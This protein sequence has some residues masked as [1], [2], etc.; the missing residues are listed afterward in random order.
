MAAYSCV[1]VFEEGVDTAPFTQTV[2]GVND[3]RTGTPFEAH[4]IL[5][6]GCLS[7]VND[8][9]PNSWPANIG[10][11][12]YHIGIA[13]NTTH[14]GAIS[15]SSLL[16]FG[17][18]KFCGGGTATRNSLL[19]ALAGGFGSTL[20][21]VGYLSAVAA[22]SV[23]I[24]WT[25]KTTYGFSTTRMALF[26]GGSD[27]NIDIDTNYNGVHA[28]TDAP[29]GVLAI[30]GLNTYGTAFSAAAGG[31]I[32]DTGMGW[33]I[34]DGVVGSANMVVINQQG[35][36]RSQLSDRLPISMAEGPP[37]VTSGTPIV[38]S[39]DPTSYTITG[40]GGEAGT[41]IGLLAFSGAGIICSS[42]VF[43]APATDSDYEL[44]LQLDPYFVL[45]ASVGNVVSSS[46]DTAQ[47]TISYGWTDR[48]NVCGAWTGENIVGNVSPQHGAAF[49]SDQYLIQTATPDGLNSILSNKMAL[50]PILGTDGLADLTFTDTDGTTPSIIWFA[51][52]VPVP[53]P[54]P[55]PTPVFRTREVVRR[56]LRR[57]PIVWSEKGGLQTRVR[58]NLFA[59]DMQPGVGT[60]GTPDPLVMIRASKDGGFTWGNERRLTAGRVGEFFDRIN[61]WQWG[62]GRDWVF[63]VA[64]TDPVT[65]NLVGAYL[66]AEGGEN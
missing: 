47:G 41:P 14:G 50:A 40:E 63:E 2:T 49:M 11:Y 10:G 3:G 1:Q 59:V 37:R 53:T 19:T 7:P 29:Q 18:G 62:Q 30:T 39:W 64:C 28:T 42:G 31:A 20:Q 32:S 36:L 17:I 60:S 21:D 55:P 4:T 23:D 45:F 25:T 54:P 24:T 57:A 33:A 38:S 6:F 5:F 9:Y 26:L 61:A 22:G 12:Q 43:S 56:R 65:W 58:I 16:A 13:R 15:G 51:V 44:D 46:V 66:D 48:I 52:G 35:N 8:F 34:R 27:W